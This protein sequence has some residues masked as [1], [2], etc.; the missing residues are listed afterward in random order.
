MMFSSRCSEDV[1]SIS[2][3]RDAMILFFFFYPC[4][5]KWLFST[6]YSPVYSCMQYFF[7]FLVFSIFE[8]DDVTVATFKGDTATLVFVMAVFLSCFKHI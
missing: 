8:D 5:G 1:V 4:V 7:V 2:W 6:E 3:E